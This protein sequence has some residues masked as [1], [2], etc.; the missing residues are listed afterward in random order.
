MLWPL[1]SYVSPDNSFSIVSESE[2]VQ[3]FASVGSQPDEHHR[4]TMSMTTHRAKHATIPLLRL[5]CCTQAITL[6]ITI[7]SRA[8]CLP[9]LFSVSSEHQVG[10]Q[11]RA[12]DVQSQTNPSD[13]TRRMAAAA[14]QATVAGPM[15][16]QP[17]CHH[18]G[19]ASS[20]LRC[21][22]IRKNIH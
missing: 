16:F 1:R 22:F 15:C 18:G 19:C 7:A 10:C 21:R 5:S 14:W 17:F 13:S 11:H 4:P 9:W 6:T 2:D 8:H 12:P 3:C 20:P